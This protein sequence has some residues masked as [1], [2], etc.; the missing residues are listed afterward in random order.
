MKSRFSFQF[1]ADAA[2]QM[3]PR[4][5][6]AYANFT[7]TLATF[8]Q[9]EEAKAAP[10]ARWYVKKRLAK[11]DPVMGRITVKHG[12]YLDKEA[13]GRALEIMGE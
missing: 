5:A 1:R 10:L 6:A 4:I 13:I 9:I 7:E 11:L 3:A 2:E 8:G 12:G